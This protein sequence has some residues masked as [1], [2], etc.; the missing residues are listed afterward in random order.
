MIVGTADSI[1]TTRRSG[2]GKCW[3][4]AIPGQQTTAPTIPL[5]GQNG[6]HDRIVVVGGVDLWSVYHRK[7]CV[8]TLYFKCLCPNGMLVCW[9][10]VLQRLRCCSHCLASCNVNAMKEKMRGKKATR[11][12][13]GWNYGK[14]GEEGWEKTGGGR[15]GS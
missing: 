3:T 7:Y 8:P 13:G 1:A 12:G 10:G 5:I 11:G 9:D 6:G 4:T 15:K 14:E 2:G